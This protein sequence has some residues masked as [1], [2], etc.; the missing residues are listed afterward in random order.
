MSTRRRPSESPVSTIQLLGMF[1]VSLVFFAAAVI[2]G[3]LAGY[4]RGM[5]DHASGGPPDAVPLLEMLIGGPPAV[6]EASE[7]A[8][9]PLEPTEQPA[10][11]SPAPAP[12][13]S[14]VPASQPPAQIAPTRPAVS[15]DTVAHSTHLQVSAGPQ[16][17]GA[18][19]LARELAAKGYPAVVYSGGSDGLHRVILGPYDG[20]PA[21]RAIQSKL[22]A[23]GRDSLIRIR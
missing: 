10:K 12:Q 15:P 11:Q 3:F 19:R 20:R 22:K 18:Q 4:Q 23:D 7:T 1:F 2:G 21:A 17:R 9:E 16:L 5:I 8:T 6:A 13:Q 14:P